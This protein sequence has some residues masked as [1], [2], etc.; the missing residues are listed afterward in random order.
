[1]FRKQVIAVAGA[2]PAM[3]VVLLVWLY[4]GD[5]FGFVVLP[6][7]TTADRLAFVATWLLIPGWALLAGVFGASRRG[8]IRGAIE[9]TRTPE[10]WSLEVNLRY[11]Q[12]TIEQVALAAIA[13]ACLALVLPHDRLVLIPAMA[14]LFGIGR[15]TFWIGYRIH[16][17]ARTFGMTL[18]AFPTVIAYLW[19][20]ARQLGGVA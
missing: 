10:S 13:W 7:D 12:N 18:T 2:L 17:L 3:P 1:M 6:A 4:V 16:P 15:L 9:G 14:V 20:A 8:F 19:L 11:N 5:L